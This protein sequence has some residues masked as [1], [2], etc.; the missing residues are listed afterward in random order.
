[1]IQEVK[2]YSAKCDHCKND[3]YDDHNGWC[4]MSD[5]T[6]MQNVLNE[7]GWHTGDEKYNE[8][9]DGE[10]YCPECWSYDDEDKFILR[11]D[12]KDKYIN[13]IN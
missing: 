6:S 7:E 3:W 12:R 1:M 4:A 5:E 9:I 11:E 13:D 2:M 10:H 8:G